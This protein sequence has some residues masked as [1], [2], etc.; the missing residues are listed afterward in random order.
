MSFRPLAFLMSLLGSVTETDGAVRSDVIPLLSTEE[1]SRLRK[2]V[3][4]AFSQAELEEI[5]A[6]H[7][8]LEQELLRPVMRAPS[9]EAYW[10]TRD[11]MFRRGLYCINLS[12]GFHGV[13]QRKLQP[14]IPPIQDL[15]GRAEKAFDSQPPRFL[16]AA[17]REN[18]RRGFEVDR[19]ISLEVERR[20]NGGTLVPSVDGIEEVRA[21]LSSLNPDDAQRHAQIVASHF[22]L[23]FWAGAI[24]SGERPASDEV[25]ESIARNYADVARAMRVLVEAGA[26]GDVG[27]ED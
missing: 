2:A 24:M 15:L 22:L 4:S 6:A 13:L 19:Q 27:A 1:A 9:K 8:R 17:A 14:A 18:L 12:A 7:W 20:P 25:T 10:A 16:S 5:Q 23:G 26:S 3:R 21:A 11:E